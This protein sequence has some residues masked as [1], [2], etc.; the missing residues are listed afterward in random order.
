MEHNYFRFLRKKKK[1]KKKERTKQTNPTTQKTS[2]NPIFI[3][4]T[5]QLISN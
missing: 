1:G 4:H 2:D 3:F 5:T